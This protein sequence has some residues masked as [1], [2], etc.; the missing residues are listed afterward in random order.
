MADYEVVCVRL[1]PYA[2][3]SHVIGVGVRTPT[4]DRVATM[5]VKD[6]R[7][8]IR[9]GSDTFHATSPS[10]GR[11]LNVERFKCHGVKTIRAVAGDPAIDILP[12]LRKCA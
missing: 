4:G 10:T 12:F 2:E 1:R 6:V 3:H 9:R 11:Q 7:R 8:A 5:T